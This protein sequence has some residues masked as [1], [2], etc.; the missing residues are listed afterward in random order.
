MNRYGDM[1][2]DQMFI[3]S[4]DTEITR[5]D[6]LKIRVGFND[7]NY[8]DSEDPND[9]FI[10]K[11]PENKYLIGS[12]KTSIMIPIIHIQYQDII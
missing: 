6:I 11:L 10:Y 9:F 1:F 3:V 5:K 12:Y 7:E 8:I 2:C 4:S